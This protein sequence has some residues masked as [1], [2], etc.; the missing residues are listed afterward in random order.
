[1]LPLTLPVTN[2]V[3]D[4]GINPGNG[5]LKLTENVEATEKGKLTER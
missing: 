3:T 5:A 2:T 1:L 4:I